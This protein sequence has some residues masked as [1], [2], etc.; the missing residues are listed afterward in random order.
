VT[1]T[2]PLATRDAIHGEQSVFIEVIEFCKIWGISRTAFYKRRA[3]GRVGPQPIEKS[4]YPKWDR[5]EVMA[6]FKNRDSN[7]N[8]HGERTWS[9]AWQR[10]QKA[11]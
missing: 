7:G 5:A 6:W 4:G 11:N 3:L 10:L 1:T 8:L 9:S 2:D